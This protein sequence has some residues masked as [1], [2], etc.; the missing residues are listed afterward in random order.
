MRTRLGGRPG[1]VMTAVFLDGYSPWLQAVWISK[2]VCSAGKMIEK[3]PSSE[4]SRSTLFNNL[5]ASS[6]SVCR[7]VLRWS[8]GHFKESMK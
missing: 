6:V 4:S 5:S 2:S 7:A 8:S 3:R 1:R